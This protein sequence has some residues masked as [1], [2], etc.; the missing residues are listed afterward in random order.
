MYIGSLLRFVKNQIL[1]LHDNVK[2]ILVSDLQ[3]Y[4]VEHKQC[5]ANVADIG[6]R[7]NV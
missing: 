6:S 4:L 2:I 1:P 5:L 3:M 7:T